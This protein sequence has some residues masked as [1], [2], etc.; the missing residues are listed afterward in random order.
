[1]KNYEKL[2]LQLNPLKNYEK[3]YL[4]ANL[5]IDISEETQRIHTNQ[6]KLLSPTSWAK[7]FCTVKFCVSRAT[8]HTGCIQKLIDRRFKK[9]VILFLNNQLAITNFTNMWGLPH[10][11]IWKLPY[12]DCNFPIFTFNNI[13][14]TYRGRDYSSLEAI[15]VDTST[16]S[17]SKKNEDLLYKNIYPSILPQF[18]YKNK[19]FFFIF[20]Q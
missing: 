6:K 20:V 17:M 1:M 5:L 18:H 2:F 4:A 15:I 11:D 19:P 12:N 8:G 16:Y 3:L 7:E 9:K 13:D 14:N 10:D